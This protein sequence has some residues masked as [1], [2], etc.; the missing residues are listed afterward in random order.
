M[1]AFARELINI[2]RVDK[3]TGFRESVAINSDMFSLYLKNITVLNIDPF[4]S[5]LHEKNWKKV[6]YLD[7]KLGKDMRLRKIL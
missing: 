1:Y 5:Y 2:K 3:S 7:R 4:F 6:D